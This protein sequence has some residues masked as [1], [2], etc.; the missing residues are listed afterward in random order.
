MNYDQYDYQI[1]RRWGVRLVGW[2]RDLDFKSPS[3]MHNVSDLQTLRDALQA[4]TCRWIKLNHQ[5]QQ[6]FEQDIKRREA[7]GS[8]KKKERKKRSDSG[9][10][11]K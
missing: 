1:V 6:E 4:K 10:Q 5:E 9:K 2:P 3:K 8:L 7:E 11:R